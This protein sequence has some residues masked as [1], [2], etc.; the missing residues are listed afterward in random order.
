MPLLGFTRL[1]A[2][3]AEIALVRAVL[4][5]WNVAAKPV[6]Y[7]NSPSRE[8]G[9]KPERPRLASPYMGN[10]KI[11][12]F[13]T[14]QFWDYRESRDIL[15]SVRVANPRDLRTFQSVIAIH[16]MPCKLPFKPS[17]Q[18][19]QLCRCRHGEMI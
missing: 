12:R 6:S 17:D 7:P 9:W 13:K 16:W 14:H 2:L 11:R 15:H 3:L 18:P 19:I 5:V 10:G 1:L 8:D 4:T